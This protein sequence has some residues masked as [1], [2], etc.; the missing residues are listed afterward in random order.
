MFRKAKPT[1]DDSGQ[2]NAYVEIKRLDRA[3]RKVK[4]VVASL[5]S[6][7]TVFKATYE[8][9]AK[10]DFYCFNVAS[11]F[12]KSYVDSEN[13]IINDRIATNIELPTVTTAK[14]RMR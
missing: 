7:K 4:I 8:T 6:G 5:D 11:D 3:K 9:T 12:I 10:T 14:T 2:V 13:Y 1:P